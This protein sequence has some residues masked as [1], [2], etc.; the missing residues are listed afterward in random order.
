MPAVTTSPLLPP[1]FTLR[2]AVRGDEPIVAAL[3]IAQDM[4]D[5]G[6]AEYDEDEVR[7]EWASPG[8]DPERDAWL[9]FTDDGTP[10]AF[11]SVDG[12]AVRVFTDP[13]FKGRG[14]GAHLAARAEEHAASRGVVRVMQQ[15][16]GT[17]DAARDLLARRGYEND[18]HYW[19]MGIDLAGVTDVPLPA[20]P[21]GLS[22]RRYVRERDE[23]GVHA[24]LERAFA[25]VPGNVS[26]SLEA[27]RESWG[28]PG[29]ADPAL[30]TVVVGAGGELA[31]VATC[32]VQDERHAYLAQL[33]V[34]PGARGRGLGRALL[35]ETFR[36]ARAAGA[37]EVTL[38]VNA[39]NPNATA[40]YEAAGMRVKWHS[41]RW[42]KR[43]G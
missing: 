14:V 10:A 39:A 3:G 36:L 6:Q 17:G 28:R 37:V 4:D 35:L 31:G 9:V 27:W 43:L 16:F 32:A 13:R 20:W 23:S 12:E 42:I 11:A 41:D 40:L 38:D 24:L 29:R 19:H 8:F 25:E 34:D 1:G 33:G 22:V 2:P 5:L 30:T 26:Q 21:D 18:Q 7:S 15:V